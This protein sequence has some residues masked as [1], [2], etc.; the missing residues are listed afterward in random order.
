MTLKRIHT[1]NIQSH[2]DVTIMLPKTGIVA[3]TGNNSNGKSV[4]SKVT[5]AILSNDISRPKERRTLINRKHSSGFVEYERYDGY[6]LKVVIHLEA[7]QTFAELTDP[8]GAVVRRYLS[9]KSI[10]QLVK[11]FG[12]NYNSE[13]DVSLNIHNDDDKFLFVNTKHTTNCACLA[14]TLSDSYG[15]QAMQQLDATLSEIKET[16]KGLEKD[17]ITAETILGSLP[18][19]DIEETDKR[20][21][22]MLYIAQNLS[23]FPATRCPKV[24]GVP[25]VVILN[26]PGTLPKV[27]Y[28]TIIDLPKNFPDIVQLGRD[29]NDVLK[30]VCPTCKRA[31]YS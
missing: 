18:V 10:P 7:A 26:L 20:R 6:I 3:F 28:P 22:K 12:F 8:N 29:V 9:D 16:V 25:N 30:G 1:H 19:C 13:H 31:F 21:K 27:K 11:E 15:E 17:K 2:G 14:D 4:I 5:N 24:T 23:H